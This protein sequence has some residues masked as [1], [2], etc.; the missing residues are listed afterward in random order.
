M[1]DFQVNDLRPL[2]RSRQAS[3]RIIDLRLSQAFHD[4]QVTDSVT[5][6]A[7][8]TVGSHYFT[9]LKHVDTLFRPGS[10]RLR[11]QSMHLVEGL[12]RGLAD[13]ESDR[14]ADPAHTPVA[15]VE[16]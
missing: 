8:L 9:L 14:L 2:V 11:R 10:L 5:R 4:Q 1:D 6:L 3:P 13:R 15:V 16:C 7:Q 12:T